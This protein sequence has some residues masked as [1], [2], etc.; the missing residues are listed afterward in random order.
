M[1]PFTV[2]NNQSSKVLVP[3]WLMK[4]EKK[5]HSMSKEDSIFFESILFFILKILNIFIIFVLNNF[6]IF[7]DH[8]IYWY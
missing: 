6:F 7:S 4:L 1:D 3:S 8:F 2:T 5:E